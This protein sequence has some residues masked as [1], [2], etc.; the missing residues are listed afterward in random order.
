MVV[1]F[2]KLEKM[3][4]SRAWRGLY[5]IV[6]EAGRAYEHALGKPKYLL[7]VNLPWIEVVAAT[8][9]SLSLFVR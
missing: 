3:V 5:T 2:E 6:A 9:F 4:R 7:Y 8:V 1:G